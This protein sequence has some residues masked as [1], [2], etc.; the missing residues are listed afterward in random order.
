MGKVGDRDLNLA[1]IKIKMN[2]IMNKMKISYGNR[3]DY[4]AVVAESF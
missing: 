1:V 3:S 2:I 4:K